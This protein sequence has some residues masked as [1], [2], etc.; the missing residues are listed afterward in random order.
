MPNHIKII[1]DISNDPNTGLAT[2]SYRIGIDGEILSG[3]GVF[4]K[5]GTDTTVYEIAA[6]EIALSH[7]MSW[8]TLPKG[9]NVELRIDH[10]G[11]I[12]LVSTNRKSGKSLHSMMK[13]VKG[14]GINIGLH[15]IKGEEMVAEH[16]LCHKAALKLLKARR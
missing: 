14:Q 3:R 4:K 5:R 16:D 13:R 6:Q 10:N 15:R 7:L 8:F 9:T 1:S 11:G 2:Y 12:Q